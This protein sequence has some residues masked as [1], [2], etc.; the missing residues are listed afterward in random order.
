[1]QFGTFQNQQTSSQNTYDPQQFAQ[2]YTLTASSQQNEQ[3]TT[4]NQAG[5]NSNQNNQDPSLVMPKKE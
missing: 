5:S 1:M 3:S 2:Q 4:K